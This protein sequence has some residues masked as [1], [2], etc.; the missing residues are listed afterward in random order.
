[1]LRKIPLSISLLHRLCLDLVLSPR[2]VRT[3][4]CLRMIL[5]TRPLG[6]RP[7]FCSPVTSTPSFYP[8]IIAKR[9][10][11]SRRSMLGVVVDSS[12][13]T[14]SLNR[15]RLLPSHSLSLTSSWR[16]PL[17]GMRDLSPTLL[18]LGTGGGGVGQKIYFPDDG[19]VLGGT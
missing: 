1:M 6:H 3:C 4:G 5:R 10:R 9:R 14:V 8:T 16:L 7:R 18:L 11:L 2:N 17:C 15:R 13:R 19:F 12:P